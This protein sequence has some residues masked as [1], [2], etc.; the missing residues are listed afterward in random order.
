MTS[1]LTHAWN[2][3]TAEAA[4]LPI[5]YVRPEC[6]QSSVPSF[7]KQALNLDSKPPGS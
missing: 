5:A 2:K 4:S 3:G 7:A 1:F 6:G